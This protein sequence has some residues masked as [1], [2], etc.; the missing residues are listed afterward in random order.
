MLK[1]LAT[2]L[3]CLFLGSA[4]HGFDDPGSVLREAERLAWL[5]AWPRAAPLF[6]QAAVEFRARGDDR[7]ALYAEINA[8]RGRLHRMSVAD[9]SDQFERYLEHPL[10]QSDPQMRLRVLVLKGETDE[11]LDPAVAE[12]SWRAAHELAKELG[13]AAWSNRALGELGVVA[14][15]RGDIGASVINLTTALKVAESTKDAPSMI[16]WMTLFGHGYI[17]MGQPDKALQFYERALAVTATIPGHLVPVMTYLGM[18]DAYVKVGKPDAAAAAIDRGL[19]YAKEQGAIGYQ[20]ELT[21]KLGL[22]A[23]ARNQKEQAIA[24]LQQAHVLATQA[25]GNRI[26]AGIALDL[27]RLQIARRQLSAAEETLTNGIKVAR[28]TREPMMLPKLLAALGDLKTEERQYSQG[29]ELVDEAADLIEGL[30]ANVSSP[31]IRGQLLNVMNDVI[32]TRVRLEGA[33]GQNPDRF[34]A[35]IEQARGRSLLELLVGAPVASVTKPPEL[36]AGERELTRLQTQLFVATNRRKRQELLEQIAV[37]EERLAPFSTVMFDRTRK[38]TG[39]GTPSAMADLRTVQRRLRNDELFLEYVLAD[40]DSYVVIVRKTDARVQRLV[41]KATIVKGL[42]ALLRDVRDGQDQPLA[43]RPLA[44][45]LIDLIPEIAKAKRLIVSVDGDLHQLPFELLPSASGQRLLAS[46]IV[47]YSPSGSVFSILR[48]KNTGPAKAALAVS[49][50]DAAVGSSA[51]NSA[52]PISRGVYDIDASKLPPLPSANDET[53][54]VASLLGSEESTVLI[55]QTATEA[56]FKRQRLADYR[57]IHLAAHGIPSTKFPAR[58][59]IL[60]QPGDGDDGLLQA[61]EVLGLTIRADLVTLSACDTGTGT[62][63]GQEGV[64]SLVRPFLAAGAKSVVANL[65]A[66]DDTFSLTFMRE[67]YGQL[68]AGA[69]VGTAIARAKLAM[70]HRFGA[71]ATP[72]LWGGVLV[73]GDSTA[74]VR[75]AT[76]STRR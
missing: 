26:I 65:W 42:Q 18:G 68:A 2:A 46:H 66:A 31:W 61:R 12:Q 20:A 28:A 7:N 34:W 56:A 13:D 29:R 40:P 57:V 51:A 41:A 27:A 15:L 43:A 21:W 30:L 39:P 23:A 6:E 22:L 10:V 75:T 60:L 70:I 17:E 35:V 59:A 49:G 32:L 62:V 8:L 38:V 55:G 9:A 45:D 67:A 11:D 50:G 54:A 37:L 58:S 33:A 44:A 73:Y 53:R 64:S 4:V 24:H 14:F 19:A 16:R 69:D 48:A 5:K 63:Q 74:T 72:K 47:S 1:A 52:V 71:V 36:R 25:G 3:V 76:P